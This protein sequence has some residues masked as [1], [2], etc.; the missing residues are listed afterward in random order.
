MSQY[1]ADEL[2]Y[3]KFFVSIDRAIFCAIDSY[4]K[5]N[6]IPIS[7]ETIFELFQYLPVGEIWCQS[8]YCLSFA[9]PNFV[10]QTRLYYP[11][12]E[13]FSRNLSASIGC[14]VGWAVGP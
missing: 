13:I 2:T 1:R 3:E 12:K 4:N 9:M 11:F 14:H 10:G 8:F 6:L 7:N 5:T